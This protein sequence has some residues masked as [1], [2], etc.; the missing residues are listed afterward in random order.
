MPSTKWQRLLLLAAMLM[1]AGCASTNGT[2]Y[3][4]RTPEIPAA[5]AS[6]AES[7]QGRPYAWGGVTPGGFDCS[8][9]VYYAYSEAGVRVPRTARQQYKA[10]R[11]LYVHQLAPGDLVFFAMPGRFPAHVGV[12]LGENRFVHALNKS[13]PVLISNLD[14][15]YWQSRLIR[16]GSL[17]R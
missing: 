1:L 7:M 15:N 17:V 16:A 13:K 4:D 10:V 2:V 12:Y 5:A 9:L 8:G 3:G 11:P 6:V 14:D